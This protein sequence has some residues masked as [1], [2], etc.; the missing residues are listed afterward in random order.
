MLISAYDLYYIYSRNPD[1]VK[2]I[3]EYSN[4][5]ILFTDSGGFESARLRDYSW[6][7]EI[8]K[9]TI[10]KV[11]TDIYASYDSV[12]NTLM[13]TGIRNGY[14]K[15][16]LFEDI[17]NSGSV[18]SSSEFMPIFHAN[19]PT[20]LIEYVRSFLKK[21]GKV[22]KFIGISER[23]CGTTISERAR[24]VYRIRN[25][26]SE[27]E[28]DDQVLHVLGCG[29]PAA[30]ALYCYYGADSFDSPDWTRTSLDI[31][32]LNLRDKTHLEVIDCKC[33]PCNASTD[34]HERL[35]LH[36]LGR[37]QEFM[38]QL[39]K[40]IVSNTLEQFLQEHGIRKSV[41]S[42]IES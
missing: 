28:E 11:D 2:Q 26:I 17:V 20:Q 10:S 32:L 1:T 25:V 15:E 22:S 33:E 4:K 38:S 23:E 6:K 24:T 18:S 41:L 31:E 13:K 9:N 3:N 21:Y 30:I 40:N 34:P 39:R 19:E 36:N 16:T 42:K 7:F 14:V 5:G 29:H 37:Y 12:V 35:L 27:Y 8:Y